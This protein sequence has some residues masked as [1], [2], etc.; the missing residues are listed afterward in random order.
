MKGV[1]SVEKYLLENTR[2]VTYARVLK[3]HM[4]YPFASLYELQHGVDSAASVKYRERR[5]P[6][7]VC[8]PEY[9]EEEEPEEYEPEY[10]PPQERPKIYCYRDY[11]GGE[12]LSYFGV[13]L[14]FCQREERDFFRK[15]QRYFQEALEADM[16]MEYE[17]SDISICDA[18]DVS[19]EM[20]EGDF[21]F[22]ISDLKRQK[23]SYYGHYRDGDWE[24]LKMYDGFDIG[25]LEKL[26]RQ[27]FDGFDIVQLEKLIP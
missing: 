11:L 6:E 24:V 25:Q 22:E 27:K 13:N 2:D 14:Y 10:A 15:V 26:K 17:R 23:F 8:Q 19:V 12:R 18:E 20:E 21:A 1:K 3:A 5:P 4:K 9:I 16:G 7:Q